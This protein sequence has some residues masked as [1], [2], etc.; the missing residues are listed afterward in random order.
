MAGSNPFNPQESM[1]LILSGNGIEIFLETLDHS[2][3]FSAWHLW[4]LSEHD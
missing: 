1:T 3:D 4:G 2:M